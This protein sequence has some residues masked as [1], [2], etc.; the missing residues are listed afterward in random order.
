MC[1]LDSQS[2]LTDEWCVCVYV[3]EREREIVSGCDI[4]VKVENVEIFVKTCHQSQT[5]LSL[6]LFFGWGILLASF[7]LF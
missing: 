6:F 7:C 4:C 2:D 1:A 3:R 5:K